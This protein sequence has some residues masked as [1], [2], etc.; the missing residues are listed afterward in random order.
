MGTLMIETDGEVVRRLAT[1]LH[2]DF[3]DDSDGDGID[4]GAEMFVYGTDRWNAD[5]DGDGAPDPDVANAPG[6]P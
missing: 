6:D 1:P 4:D 5:T 3:L 2:V